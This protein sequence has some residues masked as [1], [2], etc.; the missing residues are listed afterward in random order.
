MVTSEEF[1]PQQF[2]DM[3]C[4][5][6]FKTANQLVIEMAFDPTSKFLAAGTSDA[7]IKIFDVVGGF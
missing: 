4:I 6:L 2:K 5:K 3:E 1:T 7:H